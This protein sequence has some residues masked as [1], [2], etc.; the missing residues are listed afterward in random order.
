MSHKPLVHFLFSFG[1]KDD[2]VD[3]VGQTEYIGAHMWILYQFP[4]YMA[5][6]ASEVFTAVASLEFAYLAAPQSAHSLIMSLRFCSAGIAAFIASIYVT[7]FAEAQQNFI[8]NNEQVN[9]LFCL[10]ILDNDV[11][12]FSSV[13]FQN[14]PICFIITSLCLRDYN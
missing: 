7:V 11:A 9:H 4:Q 3:V 8:V 12:E 5:I 10:E 13:K 6:G 14:I 1:S 2:R